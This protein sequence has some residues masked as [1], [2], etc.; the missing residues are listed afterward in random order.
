M[1][2][3]NILHKLNLKLGAINHTLGRGDLGMLA[4]KDT[5]TM[6]V[7]IDM[8]HS[9]PG[10]IVGIFASVDK[11]YDR[12]PGSIRLQQSKQEIQKLRDAST[13][14]KEDFPQDKDNMVSNISELMKTRLESLSAKNGRYPDN[15]LVY[16]D[17]KP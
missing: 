5:L 15:I 3:V 4:D 1:H 11:G 17:D 2:F 7:E 13:K 6:V 16:R 8:T 14:G 12:W 10:S 9:T